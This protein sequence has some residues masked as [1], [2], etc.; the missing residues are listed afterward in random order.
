MTLA[1]GSKIPIGSVDNFDLLADIEV[2]LCLAL[3]I[4]PINVVHYLIKISQS[5]DILIYDFMSSMKLCQNELICMFVDALPTFNKI[6]FQCYSNLVALF[7]QDISV[8]WSPLPGDS[9][10]CHLFFNF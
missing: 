2:L 3:F 4:P 8:E 9:G 1:L 6:D 5:H 7:N 10:I